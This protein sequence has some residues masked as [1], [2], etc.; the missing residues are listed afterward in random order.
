MNSRYY[1][2]N[3]SIIKH[4]RLKRLEE[5]WVNF[6]IEEI[7]FFIENVC[8]P[9]VWNVVGMKIALIFKENDFLLFEQPNNLGGPIG[10]WVFW[11]GETGEEEKEELY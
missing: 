5:N 10:N 4:F 6:Y 3:I 2:L 8:F 11:V 7:L 9:I 1:I